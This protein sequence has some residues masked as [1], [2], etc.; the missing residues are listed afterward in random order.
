MQDKF[1]LDE[2]YHN[3]YSQLF[4]NQ[5]I[6]QNRFLQNMN[7]G[8]FPFSLF[9][10]LLLVNGPVLPVLDCNNIGKL[11][12]DVELKFVFSSVTN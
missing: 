1:I 6:R 12:A 8:K 4:K 3:Y 2:D 10:G 9:T 5:A 7:N 11:Q